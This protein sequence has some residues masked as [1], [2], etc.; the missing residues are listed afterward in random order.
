MRLIVVNAIV[1]ITATASLV[2]GF[3]QKSPHELHPNVQEGLGGVVSNQDVITLGIKWN[4]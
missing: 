1:A 4:L 3:I 2:D